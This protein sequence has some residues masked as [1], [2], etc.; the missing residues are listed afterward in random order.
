MILKVNYFKNYYNM[1][2]LLTY[3]DINWK[4]YLPLFNIYDNVQGIFFI[5]SNEI[6][7]CLNI[8]IVNEPYNLTIYDV[9]NH[10]SNIIWI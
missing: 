1:N 6:K 8:G 2:E 4:K 7:S 9:I 10:Q 3:Y 5:P